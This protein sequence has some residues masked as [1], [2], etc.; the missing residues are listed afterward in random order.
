VWHFG[1]DLQFDKD[2]MLGGTRCQ[3]YG[4][5]EQDL[6]RADLDEQGRQAGQAGEDGAGVRAGGIRVAQIVVHADLPESVRHRRRSAPSPRW[7][8]G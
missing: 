5:V 1:P 6:V 2:V 8:R 3:W 4:V 7:S